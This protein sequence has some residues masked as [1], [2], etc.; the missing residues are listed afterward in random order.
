MTFFFAFINLFVIALLA[1]KVVHLELPAA[2]VIFWTALLIKL[3]AGVCLGLIY[4]YY[5]DG[6]GDTILYFRDSGILSELARK[7]PVAYL[8]YLWDS[9]IHLELISDAAAQ[10]RTLYLLKLTSVFNL[11]THD[12]YWITSVYFS[13]VSFLAAWYLV[14]QIGVTVPS[15][16]CPAVVGFLFFPSAVFWSS[17][18]IKESLAMAGICLLGGSYLRVWFALPLR[19]WEYV[20]VPLAIWIVWSL[21]YY[22]LGVLFPIALASMAV[23][24][25]YAT[26]IRVHY[27]PAKVLLWL[28]AMI[29]PL[30]LISWLHPNFQPDLLMTVIV[31]NYQ[32]FQ[33][34]SEPWDVIRYHDLKPDLVSLLTNAPK[35]AFAGLFRPL[36]WEA[37]TGL[38]LFVAAENTFVLLLAVTAFWNFREFIRSPYRLLIAT[39][40]LYTLVLAT[41]LALST[42]NFGTLSRYRVGFLPA[43]VTVLLSGNPFAASLLRRVQRYLGTLAR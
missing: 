26:G 14:G 1:Y 8:A 5:Y 36:F 11:L 23:H 12:N 25:L 31:E 16:Y 40:L 33:A 37:S 24:K 18:L 4:V 29:V 10:P 41:F 17:G 28:L 20:L 42:P 43:L 15:A 39:V 2:K 13:F 9:R 32:A 34:V 35:A 27:L 22:F 38:Q 3:T 21:K 19:I 7:D 6:V 30:T